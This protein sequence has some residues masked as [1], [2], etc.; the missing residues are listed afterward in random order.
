L[1][2]SEQEVEMIRVIEGLPDGVLGF[3]AS[4]RLTAHDYAE[5]L[6][7]ALEA[8]AVDGGRLRVLLDFSGEFHGMDA[9]AVWQDVRMGVRDWNAWERIAL[10][11]D[12]TWM[13]DGLAVF[14]WAVP[15]QART[16]PASDRDAAVDWLTEP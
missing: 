3:E 7:P 14:A 4:G 15:G 2:C 11:T 5:V 9:G 10:V 16:F 13:R 8:A 1:A 12:H 6:A